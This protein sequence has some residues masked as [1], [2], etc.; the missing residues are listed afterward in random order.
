[1]GKSR[2]KWDYMGIYG[3]KGI[4]LERYRKLSII[5]K[6]HIGIIYLFVLDVV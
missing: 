1:M 6:L 4:R 3:K 2:K 5:N